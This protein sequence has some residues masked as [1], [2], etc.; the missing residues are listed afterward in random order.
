MNKPYSRPDNVKSKKSLLFYFKFLFLTSVC[1]TLFKVRQCRMHENVTSLIHLIY[2]NFPVCLLHLES[3]SIQLL[4]RIR[5]ANKR[6]NNKFFWVFGIL[7]EEQCKK[8]F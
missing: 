7:N 5:A 4:I 3:Y 1:K 2:V 8:G 6:T